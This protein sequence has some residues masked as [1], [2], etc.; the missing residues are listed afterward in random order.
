MTDDHGLE[1]PIS[2]MIDATNRADSDGF[3][4]AFADDATLTDWGR[5]FAGKAEIARWNDTENIGTQSRIAVTGV[6]RSGATVTVG[7]AVSGNGY[8]GGGSFV[9]ETG[10]DL[11]THLEISG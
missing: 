7:V 10:G 9:F 5:T 2:T 6:E 4:A 1:P 11:I 8:N 3:L